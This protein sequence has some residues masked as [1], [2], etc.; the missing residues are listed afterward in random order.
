VGGEHLAQVLDVLFDMLLHSRFSP[1]D[2]QKER[3]VICDEIAMYRD[4]PQNHVQEVLNGAL[5]PGHP[6]GR[7]ITGTVRSLN[8]LRRPELRG[9]LQQHYTANRA[10]VA[11]AGNIHHR[12]LVRLV[13]PLAQH[14][15]TGAPAGF[16]PARHSQARPVIK[17]VSRKTEQ[18]QIALGIRTCSRHD[19]RR[20]ALRLLNTLL[21]ENMSSRLF[22]AIREERGLA[23]SVYST[24]SFFSD[25]GDLVISAGLE[26]SN[27]ERTVRLTVAEM[28][29]MASRRVTASELRRARDYVVGQIDMSTESTE[30]QMNWVGEQ[31]LGYGR[32]VEPAVLKRRLA[33]VTPEQIQ[34]VAKQFFVPERLNLALVTPL[35]PDKSLPKALSRIVSSCRA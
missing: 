4:E 28:K 33:Q 15:K 20:F 31:V 1:A 5:W 24:P 26:A 13:K 19:P 6:L 25:A 9:F 34:A 23:Y 7:P 11:A 14:L 30:S 12:T 16:L 27:L 17:V 35:K 8:R 32:V 21:G 18:T 2:I 29:K 22:Q 10:V 3:D